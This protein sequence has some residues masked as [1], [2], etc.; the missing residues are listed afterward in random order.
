MVDRVTRYACGYC[1]ARYRTE[2]GAERC[3]ARGFRPVAGPG[4]VVTVAKCWGWFDGDPQWVSN[5]GIVAR[6]CSTSDG[7]HRVRP[8]AGCPN[9]NDNCFGLCCNYSFYWVVVA[10]DGDDF[11]LPRRRRG[12]HR[13]RYHVATRAIQVCGSAAVVPGT[14]SPLLAYV[15]D[16]EPVAVVSPALLA[17]AHQLARDLVGQ[18]ARGLL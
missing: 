6:G 9:G 3:E 11:D 17:E 12:L 10:V 2:R 18:R 7:L 15:F 4:Q 14:C 16:V 13:P 5:P 8:A 1:R